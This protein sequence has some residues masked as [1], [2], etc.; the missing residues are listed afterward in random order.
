MLSFIFRLHVTSLTSSQAPP[1]TLDRPSSRITRSPT[2]FFVINTF[3]YALRL[4]WYTF[5]PLLWLKNCGDQK[6]TGARIFCAD[7]LSYKT[8]SSPM[9]LL[10]RWSIFTTWNLN[11]FI[12]FS[13]DWFWHVFLAE[14]L[15]P[16]NGPHFIDNP[17][18]PFYVSSTSI[19]RW[20][21][22]FIGIIMVSE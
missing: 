5:F 2:R 8:P 20:F 12:F 11:L 9:Q 15:A 3:Y 6:V 16:A 13:S 14:I 18:L 19:N 21:T 7:G 1:W 22:H 10:L 17:I 4:C